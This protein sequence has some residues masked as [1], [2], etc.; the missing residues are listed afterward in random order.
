[1]YPVPK[2]TPLLAL[3][4]SA[5]SLTASVV[6]TTSLDEPVDFFASNSTG[7]AGLQ[8][9][10]DTTNGRRD[11]GQSFYTDSA[12]SLSAVTYRLVGDSTPG[13]GS[14]T[15]A[16]TLSIYEVPSAA[17]VPTAGTALSAQS[18]NMAGLTGT[19]ADFNKYVT[20]TMD[21]PVAL[22]ADKYYAAILSFDSQAANQNI[23]WSV[24]TNTNVYPDGRL[25]LTTDGTNYSTGT[26]MVFYTTAIPEPSQ[27]AAIAG[28]FLAALVLYRRKVR[29]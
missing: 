21:T 12:L 23:V 29:K 24:S 1:M 25:V 13:A 7:G 27:T 10:Y 14:L 18:G 20:F 8:W 17:G 6:V 19:T 15:A 5:V 26:D 11:L 16:F 2:I 28:V 3:L 9:R 22:E 4:I